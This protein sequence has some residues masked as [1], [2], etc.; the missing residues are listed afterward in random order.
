[1]GT[2][3]VRCGAK[4]VD[5]HRLWSTIANI[6]EPEGADINMNSAYALGE[7]VQKWTGVFSFFP[8]RPSDEY[9]SAPSQNKSRPLM[10]VFAC[11]S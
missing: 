3:L 11:I 7:N 6:T 8:T 4:E 2:E 5:S 9:D 10:G 1:M